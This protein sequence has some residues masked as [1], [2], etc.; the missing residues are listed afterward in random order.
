MYFTVCTICII[1]L[2]I[3]IVCACKDVGVCSQVSL[4]L[5]ICQLKPVV[6][7]RVSSRNYSYGVN[8]GLML[9]SWHDMLVLRV[10][11]PYQ[12]IL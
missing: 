7:Y 11:R 8:P 4:K 12:V 2:Y 3:C 10:G 1:Y 5:F 6:S 9:K